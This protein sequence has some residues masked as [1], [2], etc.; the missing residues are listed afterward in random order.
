MMSYDP[1]DFPFCLSVRLYDHQLFHATLCHRN[2]KSVFR[3]H[4]GIVLMAQHVYRET[5]YYFFFLLLLLLFS[6]IANFNF[7]II[8]SLIYRIVWSLLKE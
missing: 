6:L 8:S 7:V 5:Y 2:L 4:L 1:S 3:F